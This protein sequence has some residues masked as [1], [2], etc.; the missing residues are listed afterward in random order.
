MARIIGIVSGKG[1]VGKTTLGINLGAALA[2]NFD[3]NVT[4]VD[5]NVTTSH[6]GL[7]L[8]MYYC[9]VT[10]NKVL[11]SEHKIEEAINEHHSGLRVV[12]ASLSLSDLEGVD[13]TQLRSNIKGLFDKN[14]IVLLDIAP[15][16]GREAIAGMKACDELL[17]VTHPFIPSAMDVV[18]AQE[19]AKE[20]G[21]DSIGVV[22]NMTNK[23]RYEMN[24]DEIEELTKLPVIATI[25]YDTK[26]HKSL[27]L[28]MPLVMLHP[29]HKVSKEV[30]KVASHLTGE[31]YELETGIK[32]MLRSLKNINPFKGK[33][34]I[35][36]PNPLEEV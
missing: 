11:R 13:I 3:K 28:K 22:V 12:P 21:V 8:G 29:K 24:K 15:G 31:V 14:D 9:P 23:K 20:I 26:V 2:K 5:C 18:R 4:L 25:P 36:K 6:V 7:Y 17:Y 27:H 35:K 1:G 33:R 34:K 30:Y 32:K 10:L 19:V 16:L